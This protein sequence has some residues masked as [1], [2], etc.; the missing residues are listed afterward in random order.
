MHTNRRNT[1]KNQFVLLNQPGQKKLFFFPPAA[2]FGLAYQGLANIM[3]DYSIYSFNFIENENRLHEYVEIITNIQPTGPYI[4][5]GWSAAGKLIFK[6]VGALEN[7][8]FEVS[9]IIL[10]DCFWKKR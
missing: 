8:G 9:D 4:L 5:F 1:S 10:F 6:V 7:R 3:N 2:G